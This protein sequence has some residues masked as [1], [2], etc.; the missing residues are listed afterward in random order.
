MTWQWRTRGDGL[1]ELDRHD[2]RGFVVPTLPQFDVGT[3]PHIAR[4]GAWRSLVEQIAG[5]R[6]MSLP[7]CLGVIFAESHGDPNA[8]SP[9]GARGLMQ[10]MPTTAKAYGVSTPDDLFRP[11]INVDCGARILVEFRNKGFDVPQCASMYNAGPSQKT[12]GPK[13]ST[14]SPWGMVEDIGYIE[15]VVSATNFY[16]KALGYS[17]GTPRQT[18]SSGGSLMP[19]LVVGGLLFLSRKAS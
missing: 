15:R 4:T 6:G 19:L 10:I 11:H 13:V 17:G 1:I 12:G 3:A 2:G 16:T 14:K 18:R 9:A 8:V 5:P 7:W